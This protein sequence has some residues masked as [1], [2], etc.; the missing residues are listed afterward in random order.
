MWATLMEA[1]VGSK[2]GTPGLPMPIPS[3]TSVVTSRSVNGTCVGSTC[4]VS[5]A[6]HTVVATTNANDTYYTLKLYENGSLVYSG[7]TSGTTYTKTF[8]GYAGSGGSPFINP[9]LIYRAD[10]V[11]NATGDSV[12]TLTGN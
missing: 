5:A 12:T 4:T 10:I 7:S 3:I 9:D 11:Y 6:C 1:A 8:T 2:A